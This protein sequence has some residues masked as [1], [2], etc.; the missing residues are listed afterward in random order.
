MSIK[1]KKKTLKIVG[2]VIGIIIIIIG[3]F[4]LIQTI[5]TNMKISETEEKLSQIN[6]EELNSKLIEELEKTDLNVD[7]TLDTMF[8]DTIFSEGEDELE[9]FTV[10]SIIAFKNNNVIGGIEIPCFKIESDSN[11]NFKNIEYVSDC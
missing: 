11:G 6:A 5:S 1:I 9:G 3:L 10:M 2:I 4:F 7:L 8:V